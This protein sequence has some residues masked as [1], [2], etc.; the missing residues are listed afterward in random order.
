MT[1]RLSI[2]VAAAALATGAGGQA[3]HAAATEAV[4]MLS[5]QAVAGQMH[6]AQ[7]TRPRG[8]A[9]AAVEDDDAQ[10]ARDRVRAT[11]ADAPPTL[12]LMS[13]M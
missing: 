3:A 7:A 12:A 10:V 5:R 2:A 6:A 9:R 4:Q 11:W 13:R 8:G 1:R